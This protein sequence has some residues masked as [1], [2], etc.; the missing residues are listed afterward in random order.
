MSDRIDPRYAL[1]KAIL[2]SPGMAHV[3]RS[4]ARSFS[5]NIF[6]MNA[7][8]LIEITRRVRDPVQGLELMSVKN[9][10]AGA[11]AHREI[12]RRVHNFVAASMTLIG[13]TREFV[14]EN[15]T[16]TP[17]ANTY[18]ERVKVDFGDEPVAKFVQDLRNYMLHRGLPDSHM[19]L[20]ARQDPDNPDSGQELTTGVRFPTDALLAWDGWTAPSRAF[21]ERA[22]EYLDIHAFVEKYLDKVV[23]FHTWLNA[24]L[25]R[26]HAGDLAQMRSLQEQLAQL[27]QG[28]EINVM[29]GT[30]EAIDAP[31]S[32][33][34]A[35][36]ALHFEFSREHAAAID[37]AGV[38][39]LSSI[40]RLDLA[41]GT[42]A[43]FMTDRPVNAM[44]EP[45]ETP[46]LWHFDSD[47]RRVFVFIETDDGIF[48]L[49]EEAYAKLQ[50]IE[51]RILEAVWAKQTLS[52]EFVDNVILRWCR[53]SFR[54]A[55]PSSLSD[56]LVTA[57]RDAVEPVEVWIPIAYLEIEAPFD[58]GPAR[59]APITRAMLDDLEAKLRSRGPQH[60]D[61]VALLF[62]DLRKQMQGFAAVVIRIEAERDRAEQEAQ[63]LAQN[64]VGLLRF[65]SPAASTSWLLCSTALLG[66]EIIPQ[67]KVLVL[68]TDS[69]AYS[70]R[71][72]YR[73]SPYWRI[74][75]DDLIRLQ[76]VGLSAAGRLVR[77]EG[78]SEFALAV[79]SSILLYSKGTTFPDP[80]DRLVHALSSL[81]GVL[82]KHIMEPSEYNVGERMSLLL[83]QEKAARTDIEHNVREAYRLRGQHGATILVP[84]EQASLARFIGNAYHVLQIALANVPS[85]TTKADFVD[86]VERLR[87]R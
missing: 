12:S 49:D 84:N 75:R 58:I 24:E 76:Q 44:I 69:F 31:H 17:V 2:S 6:Q 18:S 7:Q 67:F 20:E 34:A 32:A 78:L 8:E 59:I 39:I 10:E 16:N 54:I 9:R 23:Q 72:I 64:V 45:I 70:A 5:F 47:G 79:R 86:A 29:P 33:D 21:I 1:Q 82:L 48:G 68:G 14:R 66:A 25:D 74:S 56:A 63:A 77:T 71:T 62:E 43:S 4:H 13:H 55:V 42:A 87:E 41:K 40:R 3:N 60:Q 27:Y 65:F 36:S 83:A 19:F 28:S 37:E 46:M 85:V 26:F 61:D 15:Y 81:E 35:P 50:P 57:S 73:E 30:A 80:I 22:G 51:D 53:S 11:Q 52:R 38:A